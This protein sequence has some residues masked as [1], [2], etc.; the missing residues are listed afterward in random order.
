MSN[1]LNQRIWIA[2]RVQR[3]F[4]SDIRAYRDEESARRCERAWRRRMNPD[5]D[6][7]GVSAV[8]VKPEVNRRDCRIRA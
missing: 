8:R 2:V 1:M 4:V 3:G 7:T 5:Y 6:E